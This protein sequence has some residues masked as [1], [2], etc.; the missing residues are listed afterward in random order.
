MNVNP[1]VVDLSHYQNVRSWSAVKAAGIVGVVNKA[2]EGLSGVDTTY[3]YRRPR[4]VDVD[5]LYG[6]YHFLRPG[7]IQAQ[8]DHFLGVAKPDETT[9]LALD[10][11]DSRVPL[12]AAKEFL[13]EV[14]DRTGRSPV[15]YSG[16][17]IKQQLGK[18]QDEELAQCR[19]WL[20]QYSSRPTWPPAWSKPW[21]WQFTGD[22]HGPL[23][24]AIDGIDGTGLDIDSYDG[25]VDHLT[26]EWAG[27][28]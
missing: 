24:H 23:P 22:G 14:K 21:L 9:L 6:A 18:H 1:I 13:V 2:T 10:H 26:A 17:L 8:V 3:A 7:N 28:V 4:V 25:T 27:L 20:A 12:T 16:F 5:I 15:L 19:L 11:E